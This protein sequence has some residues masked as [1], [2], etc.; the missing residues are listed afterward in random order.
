MHGDR[1]RSGQVDVLERKRAD[2][3]ACLTVLM[4]KMTLTTNKT[5][6]RERYDDQYLEYQHIPPTTEF[7]QLLS[8]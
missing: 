2:L 3:F 6:K 1:R 5:T 7:L 8:C 4:N